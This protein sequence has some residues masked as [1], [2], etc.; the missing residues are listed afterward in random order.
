MAEPVLIGDLIAE[1]LESLKP[2]P[3]EREEAQSP[4]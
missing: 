3:E 4:C 2:E 1:I